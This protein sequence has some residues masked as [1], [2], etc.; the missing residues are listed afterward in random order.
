MATSTDQVRDRLLAQVE[1]AQHRVERFREH[2]VAAAPETRRTFAEQGR[3]LG[4]R[5]TLLADELRR[6]V[7]IEVGIATAVDD[8]GSAVDTLEADFEATSEADAV[9]YR[10]AVDRQLRAWRTRTDQLRVQTALGAMELRDELEGVGDRLSEARSGVLF[11]LRQAADD[12]RE[13]VVDL[14]DDVE[15]V[16]VDVRH[17]VERAVDALARPRS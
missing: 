1:L 9:A 4:D 7:T 15:N 11:E 2:V 10:S 3:R 12:T 5:C 16:L 17:A 13:V 8:L 6:S 14:R